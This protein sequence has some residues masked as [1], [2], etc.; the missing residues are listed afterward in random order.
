MKAFAMY[1]P[2]ILLLY[3]SGVTL[4]TV[5]TLHPFLL[6]FSFLGALLLASRLESGK[7]VVLSLFFYFPLF[8]LLALI[9]PLFS[10]NGVT[11]LFFLNDNPVTLE[12]VLFGAAIAG[13]IVSILYW[14]RCYSNVMTSD[15]FIYLFGRAIPKLSLL[16]SMALRFLPL[17]IGQ[18][19]RIHRTQKTMGLY[20]TESLVDRWRGRL[21]V[22]MAIVTWST[23]NAVDSAASMRA[24][25]YGLKGRTNFSLFRFTWRDLAVLGLLLLL[26][27]WAIFGYLRGSLSFVFYPCMSKI[28]LT[29]YALAD[30]GGVLLLML[31]PFGTE[32][33]EIVLWNYFR[34]KI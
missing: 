7:G 19:K 30:Y 3:F 20:A 34:S 31:I 21:R 17:F 25:G 14:G 29:G 22:F 10:H 33:K 1:H 4:L 13:M 8:V 26:F 32:V 23:E 28:E 18:M 15:K 12:A 11:P 9:N 5:L 24:R 16:L 27:G 6:V 2:G